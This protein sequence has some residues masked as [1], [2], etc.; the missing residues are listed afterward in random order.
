MSEP[1]LVCCLEWK[2]V[3]NTS[4]FTSP[5]SAMDL[6]CQLPK[7]QQF[8]KSS[9]VSRK[10]AVDVRLVFVAVPPKHHNIALNPQTSIQH[11]ISILI[12]LYCNLFF[13]LNMVCL[14]LQFENRCPCMSQ[15]GLE[16][17]GFGWCNKEQLVSSSSPHCT[18]TA[19]LAALWHRVGYR[20]SNSTI[21][22]ISKQKTQIC[23]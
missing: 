11:T 18:F 8:I 19:N 14:Y 3:V 9:N 7:R 17:N 15:E 4:T 1:I 10:P 6:F 2:S 23:Q 12:S 5:F 20:F 13:F 21:F 22:K 16:T